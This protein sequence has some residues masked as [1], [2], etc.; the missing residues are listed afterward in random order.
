MPLTLKTN[1][2]IA[3]LAVDLGLRPGGDAMAA[4]LQHCRRQIDKIVAEFGCETLDA[5]LAVACARLSTYFVEIHNDAELREVEREYRKRGENAFAGLAH[6]LGD[7]VFA[8]TFAL[9]NRAPEDCRFVSVIDC[10]GEKAHRAYFSKW[11]ELAHLLTLTPQMRL[12]FCRTHVEPD[13]KDPEE[14]AMDVIAG[15]LGFY[16]PLVAPHAKGRISFDA[17]D[18][19]R[20][21][22]CPEA[23][24]VS[25]TIGLVKSWPRPAL[26]IQAQLATRREHERQTVFDFHASSLALRAVKV[27]ANE[28]ARRYQLAIPQNMRVPEGSIIAKVFHGAADGSAEEDLSWWESRGKPLHARAIRVEARCGYDCVEALVSA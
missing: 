16:A 13:Q 20:R 28:A 21:Q 4:V 14:A 10:R 18:A 9:M 5:L 15:D 2:T 3:R 24:A 6:Q 11:H 8:I 17:I 25:S 7:N 1:P 27:T 23:S 22:L 26:L 19:V 12:K